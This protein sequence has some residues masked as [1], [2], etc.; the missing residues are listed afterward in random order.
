M[1]NSTRNFN[2]V[3][4]SRAIALSCALAL[5]GAWDTAHARSTSLGNS[6]LGTSGSN[7][8]GNGV[9]SPSGPGVHPGYQLVSFRNA[10]DVNWRVGGF[11]WL[12][13]GRMVAVLWGSDCSYS[14]KVNNSPC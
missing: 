1:S 7:G 5:A 2:G 6:A 9:P 14:T 10:I 3:S 12:S 11:D 4:F 13:D 8:A